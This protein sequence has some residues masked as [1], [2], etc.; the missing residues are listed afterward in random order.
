MIV[1]PEIL[2]L[3]IAIAGVAGFIDAIA[4]GGGL[5]SIPALLWVGLP[6]L[7]ALGTNKLQA[8]FGS[9]AATVNFIHKGEIQLGHM[10][11]T[12]I[13]TFMGSALGTYCVQQVDTG[14]LQQLLPILLIAFALYF[15][16][17]PR[18]GD[19]D[20]KHRIGVCLFGFS[21]G[22]GIGFYDGFFGPGTGSFFALAFVALL[23]FNLRK[24]T[25]HAKLLNFT[26]NF[27]SLLAFMMAGHL[28]WFIG[29]TM[30]IGQLVGAWIGS[31]MVLRHGATLI[32]PILVI[33]SFAMAIKLLLD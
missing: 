18:V 7:Q 30:A 16:F 33:V 13:L 17:S 24:A 3:L 29:L 20:A 23:G 27:A 10:L 9:F 5:L 2:L 22:F 6:P 32:K 11:G 21:A 28:V 8:V 19:I 1:E 14:I 4:G 25:A 12:M 26:S 15:L 31:H